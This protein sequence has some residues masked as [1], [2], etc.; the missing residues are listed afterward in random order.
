VSDLNAKSILENWKKIKGDEL[1]STADN[2]LNEAKS[3][4]RKV[5]V[6]VQREMWKGYKAEVNL[7]VSIDEKEKADF[8]KKTL[9]SIEDDVTKYSD[10]DDSPAKI[11]AEIDKQIKQFH[12]TFEKEVARE[13]N[14]LLNQYIR[15]SK[16][17]DIDFDKSNSE[18]PFVTCKLVTKL[19]LEIEDADQIQDWEYDGGGTTINKEIYSDR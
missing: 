7:V 17:G 1:P 16:R 10:E 5:E 14:R 11:K 2:K 18:F 8:V 12:S 6:F 13:A 15:V 4:S 3:G 9:K 19:G